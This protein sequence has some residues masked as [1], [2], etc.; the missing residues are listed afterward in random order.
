MSA[1]REEVCAYINE[2][3]D[4]KLEA[5][6]PLLALLADDTAEIH[7]RLDDVYQKLEDG[8]QSIRNDDVMY[9]FDSLKDVRHKHNL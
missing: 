1:I 2:L 3:P 6:K 4:Y 9:G 5:L 7:V 8:E